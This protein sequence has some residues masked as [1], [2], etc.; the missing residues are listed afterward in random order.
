MKPFA[1]CGRVSTE[2]QRDP[3]TSRH[4]QLARS[5]SL[6]GPHG[7][8]I[9]A[10]YFDIGLSRSLPWKRRPQAIALLQ[11]LRDSDRNR[12]TGPLHRARPLAYLPTGPA[13]GGCRVPHRRRAFE[14]SSC[15]RFEMATHTDRRIA[16]VRA[17]WH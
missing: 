17:T 8:E 10:E 15:R 3:T 12:A 11:A 6:I 13:K 1:L 2:D 16:G 9:V 7:G 14:Q 5:R 4:W